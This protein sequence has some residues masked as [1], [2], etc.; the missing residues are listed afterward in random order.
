MREVEKFLP[1]AGI[2]LAVLLTATFGYLATKRQ[3]TAMEAYG[4]QILFLFIGLVGSYFF[5]R[6]TSRDAI[7]EIVEPHA[8]SAFRRLISLYRSIYRVAEIIDGE[9]SDGQKIAVVRAI[10]VEQI[11]TAEDAL[12]DWRDLVPESVEELSRKLRQEVSGNAQ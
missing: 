7:K 2:A 11:D 9:D 4:L 5:G 3:L 1:L 10:V 12:E 8:R 6:R